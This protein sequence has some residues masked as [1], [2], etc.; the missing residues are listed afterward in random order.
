[1]VGVL[2]I[3]LFITLIYY[4]ILWRVFAKKAAFNRAAKEAFGPV[5]GVRDLLDQQERLKILE[6]SKKIERP[7][8]VDTKN[9]FG[10]TTDLQ[11]M[12]D[13]SKKI[14][15]PPPIKKPFPP[16][17]SEHLIT[18]DKELEPPNSKI[19]PTQLTTPTPLTTTTDKDAQ[20]EELYAYFE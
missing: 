1:M 20:I 3:C 10:P 4:L 6:E 13:V 18:M 19:P 9:I 14:E 15:Q 17:I 7:Q 8:T 12:V 11:I 2:K 16:S 5:T